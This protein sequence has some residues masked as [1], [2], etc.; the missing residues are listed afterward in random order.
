MEIDSNRINSDSV[1]DRILDSARTIA[2]IGLSSDPGRPSFVVARYMQSHGYRIFPVNPNEAEVLGERSYSR[3]Q[4]VPERV[5]LVNIFRRSE[6]AGRHVAEA[7]EIGA[8]AVWLQ[9]GVIDTAGANRAAALGL[10]VV[11]DKC[12]LKEHARRAVCRGRS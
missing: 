7:I 11:M 4:D 6:E 9:E 3:L 1:I 12:I 8:P 10:D 2:V 5:D